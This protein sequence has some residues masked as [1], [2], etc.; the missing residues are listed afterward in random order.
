[1]GKLPRICDSVLVVCSGVA[2][3]VLGMTAVVAGVTFPRMKSLDPTLP[4]YERYDGPHWSLA[5]GWIAEAVFDVGFLI[6]G[7]MV[8][9]CILA[10]GA[11]TVAR[12]GGRTPVVRLA[13]TVVLAGLFCTHVGWLQRRMDRAAADYRDAAYQGENG[14]AAEAKASFDAMHPKASKLIGAATLSAFGLF[15]AAAWQA[16]SRGAPG[17]TRAGAG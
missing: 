5:A 13:L 9:G 17:A 1:M 15:A 8:A 11:L 4:G 3:G 7:L 12:P 14:A 10:V 2:F 6:T 16:G